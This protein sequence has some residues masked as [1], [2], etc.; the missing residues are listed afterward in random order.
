[1]LVYVYLFKK[2]VQG[3]GDSLLVQQGAVVTSYLLEAVSWI[4]LPDSP[5]H[6]LLQKQVPYS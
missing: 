3:N 1:M 2:H 5:R 4:S 6:R